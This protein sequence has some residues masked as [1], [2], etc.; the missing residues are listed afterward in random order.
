MVQE[1]AGMCCP[2]PAECC[3]HKQCHRFRH[4]GVCSH[5]ILVQ[6]F[7]LSHVGPGDL[8]A[9]IARVLGHTDTDID[10]WGAYDGL[11]FGEHDPPFYWII[12]E[13]HP[14]KG[15][16]ED[17]RYVELT[18]SL[19]SGLAQAWCVSCCALLINH[20]LG[21]FVDW[22]ESKDVK[23]GDAGVGARLKALLTEANEVVGNI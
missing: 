22:V 18:Y 7:P 5:W 16:F 1:E 15:G 9:E 12:I 4:A 10:I 21:H 19:G 13:A 17:K 8:K 20:R 2:R 3:E 14:G 23:V 11:G 6:S